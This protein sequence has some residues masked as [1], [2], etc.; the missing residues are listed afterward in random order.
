MNL[1]KI[2]QNS[3]DTYKYIVVVAKDSMDAAFLIPEGEGF[4]NKVRNQLWGYVRIRKE[5]IQLLGEVVEGVHRGCVFESMEDYFDITPF[6]L[7]IKNY[8]PEQKAL[9]RDNKI[10]NLFI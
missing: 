3:H 10:D 2:T 6:E 4:V 5:D 1:Y 9:A 7:I 8:S